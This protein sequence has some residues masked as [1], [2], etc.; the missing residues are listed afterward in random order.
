MNQPEGTISVVR[1]AQEGDELAITE[2][3]KN[4]RTW[5]M[6]R[7]IYGYLGRNVLVGDDEIESEFLLGVWLALPDAKLD[8]GNPISYMCYKGQKKVQ[9]LMR[10]RI[11]RE[12]R[13]QCLECGHTG[14]MGWRLKVP[15]C[16]K[17]SS[18]DVHTWMVTNADTT[19]DDVSMISL[20]TGVSAEMAWQLAVHGIQIEEMQARLSGRALDLFNEVIFEGINCESSRNYLQEIAN[21]WGVSTPAVAAALRRLRREIEIYLAE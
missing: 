15:A 16:T 4:I 14:I 10:S 9:S 3:I 19:N 5:H 21:R 13:Y 17:C 7:Y 12:T 2:L 20:A 11:R 8:L 1:R 18:L 6:R